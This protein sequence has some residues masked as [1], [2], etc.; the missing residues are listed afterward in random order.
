MLNHNAFVVMNL[1]AVTITQA[2][3][4]HHLLHHTHWLRYDVAVGRMIFTVCG[5]KRLTQSRRLTLQT[6]IHIHLIAKHKHASE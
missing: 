5:A 1:N 4:C 2:S 3:K 6:T